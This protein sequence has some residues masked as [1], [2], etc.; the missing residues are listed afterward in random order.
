MNKNVVSNIKYH[1]TW[2]TCSCGQSLELKKNNSSW[3]EAACKCGTNIR[4]L[5]GKLII[6]K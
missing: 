3:L 2:T 5:R 1:S 4:L 6:E